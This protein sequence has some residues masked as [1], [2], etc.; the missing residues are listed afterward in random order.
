M[1]LRSRTKVGQNNNNENEK[2]PEKKKDTNNG[3]DEF[4]MSY[5]VFIGLLLDLLAFTLILP[6]FPSLLDHYKKHD[7]PNG[8][9]NYL[10]TK[11]EAFSKVKL[12]F[13]ISTTFEFSRKKLDTK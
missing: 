9:F 5:V 1:E 11:G 12:C 2:V 10:D 7:G 13:V 3:G 8:L 6:L 4:K